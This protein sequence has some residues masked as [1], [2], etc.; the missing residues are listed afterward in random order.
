MFSAKKEI[1]H[2]FA[3]LIFLISVSFLSYAPA[4]SQ[5][6]PF[7][8]SSISAL[9][10][11]AGSGQIIYSQNPYQRMQ[12]A[13]LAKIMTLFLIFDA[14]MK[15]DVALNDEVVINKNAA[16]KKGSTMYLREGEKIQLLDLIK[17]IVIV[18][19][20]DACVAV[21][22]KLFGS[23]QTFVDRMNRKLQ[24][25]SLQN[26]KFQTVDGWP[27]ADQ[28]TTAY[29]IAMIS[30]A[31]IQK[32]P[33]ALEYHKLKEFS[34]ADI[35]LHNRNR[36]ILQDPSVDGLKTGH[37]EKAGYHLI[38]TAERGDQRYIAVIMGAENIEFREKEAMQLLDFGF[39]NFVTARLFDKDDIL[40]Q[41]SVL[42]GVKKEVGLTP[43][44]DGVITIPISQK[45]SISYEINSAAHQEAPI[46]AH[47]N[48]G[49]V[50]I[51]Y[52]KE[53][54]KS[55]P[56]VANEEIER[57]DKRTLAIESFKS[58]ATRQKYM[59]LVIII[60]I[61]FLLVQMLYII[62]LRRQSKK[63]DITGSEIAKKRLQ[64]ML[65]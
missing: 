8:A 39:S 51:T 24:D 44:E 2:A 36:L 26:T 65:K 49:K 4:H 40:S 45:E 33:Q 50:F 21:A 16:Q 59:L 37:V 48:L 58:F 62:K 30:K 13:S 64:R 27:A 1:I 18:S 46:D 23:E 55:I 14:I 28:Y 32:H 12:P 17:G 35:V 61:C 63:T 43:I 47:Q 42:N 3:L 38:A 41:L 6:C 10:I 60:L 56:L 53:V 20:N 15:G 29:D 54:L 9:L 7:N 57:K 25:L 11:D 19:G 31:Y 34:H 52:R 22:D 5:S